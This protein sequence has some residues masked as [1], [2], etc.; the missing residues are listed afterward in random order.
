MIAGIVFASI[1]AA[2]A[3]SA[4][5]SPTSQSFGDRFA[6]LQQRIA[7]DQN[8]HLLAPGQDVLLRVQMDATQHAFDSH[9]PAASGMLDVIDRQLAEIDHTLS[10]AEDGRG[11]TVHAGDSVTIALHD[12]Y[13]WNVENS[14]QTALALKIGLM[15]P[16]GVQ[17]VYVAKEPGTAI[18]SLTPK[19]PQAEITKPIVFTITILPR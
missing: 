15:F 10:R 16:R 18:L 7:D 3:A 14:D 2:N 12:P 11:I 1:V 13:F 19:T 6:R 8:R 4:P 17:G 5:V 9:D